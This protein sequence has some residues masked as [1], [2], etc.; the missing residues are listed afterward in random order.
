MSLADKKGNPSKRKKWFN[1]IPKKTV[2]NRYGYIPKR[3]QYCVI[4]WLIDG[5]KNKKH[6]TVHH[7]IEK[8]KRGNNHPT[9]LEILCEKHHMQLHH[10]FMFIQVNKIYEAYRK[11]KF[12][13]IQTT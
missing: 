3:K 4:C 2:T 13:K 11:A 1:K 7:H 6:L 5:E 9:N 10:P 8:Y 12:N